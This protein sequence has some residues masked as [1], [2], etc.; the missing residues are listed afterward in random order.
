VN[1]V[2]KSSAARLLAVNTLQTLRPLLGLAFCLS[3]IAQAWAMGLMAEPDAQ[4]CAADFAQIQQAALAQ[5]AQAPAAAKG[6]LPGSAAA[7]GTHDVAWAWLSSPTAR[8]PHGSMGSPVHAGSLHVLSRDGQLYSVQ[9]PKQRVLE[10]LQPRIVD[11]DGDGLDEIVV[12]EADSERGA[13]LVSY[14]LRSTGG[15]MQLQELARSSFLG[16]P[17]RWL[18][19]VGFADFDGDGKLDI[20]S[21]TTPH[22]GGVLTLYRYAPPRI[23]PFAKAMDV[24][25]HQMG[26]PNL[27]MH[28]ILSLPG[29]R[30]T[31]IVPDMSRRA[32]HALRWETMGGKAQ[33]KELADV[34]PLPG[35]VVYLMPSAGASACAQLADG[36]WWRIDL[37]P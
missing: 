29:T 14:G 8:Y 7:R 32:L 17:F 28:A 3:P 9:L 35:R 19:P 37:M 6:R 22:V 2:R 21:V 33:W 18:N 20:A 4:R 36:S 26:E 31:V 16:L 1:S 27:Q 24:S 25:N 34:K 12:I 23:E 15:K 10:D 5:A 13:A 11:L 30:P